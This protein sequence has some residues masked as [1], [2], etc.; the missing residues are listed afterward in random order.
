MTHH[1]TQAPSRSRLGTARITLGQ[2]KLTVPILLLLTT[3]LAAPCV[4]ATG[5]TPGPITA[6]DAWARAT[7]S[8]AQAGAVYVTIADHGAPDALIGAATPVAAKAELHE[9]IHDGD[10]MKMRPVAR[11]A[12]SASAPAVLAPGGYH[13]ML[14]GLKKPLSAGQTFP[15]SLRFEKAGTV[16]TVVTVKVAGGGGGMNMGGAGHDTQ[17]M[18]M[19]G[20][21]MPAATKP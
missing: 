8:P 9:T 17:H 6:S 14:T 12:V 15:L 11:L 10:V 1:A 19:P 3:L 2:G 7:M 18:N 16:E 20:M 5:Q 13:I 21:G 4:A